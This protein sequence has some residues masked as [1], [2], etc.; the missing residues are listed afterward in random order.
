GCRPLPRPR[1]APGRGPRPLRPLPERLLARAG[2]EARAPR[3][4][5]HRPHRGRLPRRAHPVAVRRRRPRRRRGEHHPGGDQPLRR[6]QRRLPRPDVRH[7]RTRPPRLRGAAA[8]LAAAPRPR[9]AAP[10]GILDHRAR[11]GLRH[12]RDPHPRRPR[13]RRRRLG[14]RRPQELDQPGGDFRPPA[15]P[16]PDHPARS[17]FRPHQGAEPLLGR[18]PGS[19]GAGRAGGRAGADDVQLRDLPGDLHG[20]A[21]ARRRPGR[22][23]GDGVPLRDRRLERRADPARRRGDRRWSLVR[24]AGCPLRERARGVRPPDRR[25]PGGPVPDRPGLRPGRRR[26]RRPVAGDGEVRR[27]RAMRRR[28]EHGQALGERGELG[29]RQRLPRYLRRQRL[30]RRERRRAQVPRDAP[31]RRRPGRQQP[32][33]R[34]PRAARAGDAEVVL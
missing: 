8:T 29:G 5:C 18:P 30:R 19:A 3:C 20:V 10:P 7:D 1:R 23:G 33:P 21:P 27:W 11:G 4:L 13:R 28:G 6:P 24:R 12:D 17:A 32:D 9:R 34:L 16:G 31:L 15:A 22:R 25:Q 2:P 26:R 14:R